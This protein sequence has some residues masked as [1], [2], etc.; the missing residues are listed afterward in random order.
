MPR[1]DI[2]YHKR[3]HPTIRWTKSAKE[4]RVDAY[5]V[6][7]KYLKEKVPK[8][9]AKL[10]KPQIPDPKRLRTLLNQAISF[11]V[12]CCVSQKRPTVV[13]TLF[14]D[15]KCHEPQPPYG[16]YCFDAS[17]PSKKLTVPATPTNA[18]TSNTNTQNTNGNGS[19][20]SASMTRV[21]V[22]LRANGG[23]C[24]GVQEPRTCV[25]VGLDWHGATR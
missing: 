14:V 3:K 19:N 13:N 7:E 11:Q 18:A 23:R 12:T 24:L 5:P 22:V 8:I 10:A 20:V 16:N 15:H 4:M 1:T 6:L 2:N 9:S 21:A 17:L 25:A